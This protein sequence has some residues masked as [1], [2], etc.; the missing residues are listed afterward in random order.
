[1]GSSEAYAEHGFY[2]A[3]MVWLHRLK[4]SGGLHRDMGT[5]A[6][7]WRSTRYAEMGYITRFVSRFRTAVFIYLNSDFPFLK[8]DSNSRA[9]MYLLYVV[10]HFVS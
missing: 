10:L 6:L 3:H 9:Q 1:M 7:A 8:F 5:G 2:V 4:T